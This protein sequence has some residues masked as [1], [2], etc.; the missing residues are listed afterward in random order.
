MHLLPSPQGTHTAAPAGEYVT[1]QHRHASVDT[2]EP[3]PLTLL[4]QLPSAATRHA[5][6]LHVPPEYG[7]RLGWSRDV[8]ASYLAPSSYML[9][10]IGVCIHGR[11]PTTLTHT[12]VSHTLAPQSPTHPRGMS[13]T[14]SRSWRSGSDNCRNWLCTLIRT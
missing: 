14:P 11:P 6:M 9:S 7:E 8:R 4:H 5:F 12:Y 10:P 2:H 13:C 3:L 1:A